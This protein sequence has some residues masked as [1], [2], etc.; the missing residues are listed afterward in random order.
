MNIQ[1]NNQASSS[2]IKKNESSVGNPIKVTSIYK[3][4]ETSVSVTD[5]SGNNVESNASRWQLEKKLDNIV[6]YTFKK[7][8]KKVTSN[9][10]NKD[11]AS[12]VNSKK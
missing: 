3:N 2:N 7:Y 11:E 10:S 5:E 12:L 9:N 8:N 4:K 6:S 1:K